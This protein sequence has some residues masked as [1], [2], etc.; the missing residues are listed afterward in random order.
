MQTLPISSNYSY[1]NCQ[2]TI[3]GS[4]SRCVFNKEKQI[5]CNYTKFFRDDL[6]WIHFIQLLGQKYKNTNKVN[7]LD[8]ACSDG[9]ESVSLMTLLV[10]KLQSE[11]YK[12]FPILAMDI[13]SKIISDAQSGSYK[14]NKNDLFW[15]K[16]LLKDY[17]KYFSMHDTSNLYFTQALKLL[18]QHQ[19]NIIFKQ[20]D[21]ISSIDNL[22]QQNNVILCRNVLPYL[23]ELKATKF[24]Y[25]LAE[26]LDSTSL[27][28]IGS[29]DNGHNIDDLVRNCGFKPCEL[30]NVYCKY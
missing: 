11:A 7:I 28:V 6:D 26:K 14:V 22:Q 13:D 30:E 17:S 27:L 8:L 2:N 18:P 3:F 23:K 15:I 21:L 20:Q 1:Q 5:I 12:F 9:S 4:S 24:V 16:M 10:H 25:D 19:G 29:Y